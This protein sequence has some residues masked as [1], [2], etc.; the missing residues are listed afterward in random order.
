MEQAS[1]AYH[2]NSKLIISAVTES[3]VEMSTSFEFSITPELIESMRK[4][5]Q[6]ILL[7]DQGLIINPN[8]D[9]NL[10]KQRIQKRRLT[11]STSI[12]KQI[13]PATKENVIFV[14]LKIASKSRFGNLSRHL[15][16]VL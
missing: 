10:P 15:N 9:V 2:K 12:L 13:L 3:L 7:A 5:Q 1:I 6:A 4:K 16:N 8:S 14:P 11:R